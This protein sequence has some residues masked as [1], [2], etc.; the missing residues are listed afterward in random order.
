[1][2][3]TSL[4]PF[5]YC[6]FVSFEMAFLRFYTQFVACHILYSLHSSKILTILRT[7]FHWKSSAS[8]NLICQ[9]SISH[10]VRRGLTKC[11]ASMVLFVVSSEFSKSVFCR[12]V[13]RV[14]W[15]PEYVHSSFHISD[16]LEGVQRTNRS[17]NARVRE[18]FFPHVG[19][20][21]WRSWGSSSD[22]LGFR[23]SFYT[24]NGRQIWLLCWTFCLTIQELL[25]R[26]FQN[27]LDMSD[28]T[29]EFR[30][31]CN[32]VSRVNLLPPPHWQ[33]AVYSQIFSIFV[34]MMLR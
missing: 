1:M 17:R 16:F 31:A 33:A 24:V 28:V 18:N 30:E 15:L 6:H 25:V 21:V 19:H 5:V 7:S 23:R 3:P 20:F 14:A 2:F 9:L 8:I 4:M 22:I 32:A 11:W 12:L 13:D 26:H 27:L 29:D 34:T 10:K